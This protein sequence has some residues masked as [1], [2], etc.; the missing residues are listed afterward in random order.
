MKMNKII[1]ISN[2]EV[3]YLLEIHNKGLDIK[4]IYKILVLLT[5]QTIIITGKKDLIA[6]N[7]LYNLNSLHNHNILN[8]I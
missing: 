5:N 1:K 3:N 7:N 8:S 2:K 6:K 4:L